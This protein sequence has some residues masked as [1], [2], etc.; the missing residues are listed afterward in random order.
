M[1]NLPATQNEI[2]SIAD[3]PVL[4]P[5][6]LAKTVT[7]VQTAMKTVM[8]QDVHYG[9]IPGTAKPT[10]YKQGAEKLC[11]LFRLQSEFKIDKVELGDGHR[12]YT[13]I[14][15]LRSGG[16]II[17]QGVGSCST[18]EKKYRYRSSEATDTGTKPPPSYYKLKDSGDWK[19]AQEAIGGR[20]FKVLKNEAGQW[21]IHRKG[22]GQIENPDIADLWN[23]CL[24]IAKKRAHIDA[25]LTATGASDCFD[26]D[27]EDYEEVMTK[28]EMPQPEPVP[29]PKAEYLFDFSLEP[30]LEP[31]VI[32]KLCK[33]FGGRLLRDQV[34]SFPKM[35][36]QA[37]GKPEMDKAY[38]IGNQEK[39]T[40]TEKT[41]NDEDPKMPNI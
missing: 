37:L 36:G 35:V 41:E 16:H 2:I 12:E 20:D 29:E 30:I 14:C 34:Y 7:D 15:T 4:S 38:F 23:T 17:A 26:Q 8:K 21:T 5:Q 27:L 40:N 25:T 24:K 19:G 11:L 39:Q 18:M 22:E 3:I 6:Q 1:E 13:V 9:K 33:R 10:L 28:D 32:E 31:E